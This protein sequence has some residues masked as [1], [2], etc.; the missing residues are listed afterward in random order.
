MHIRKESQPLQR[1]RL[2]TKSTPKI[3]SPSRS[4][5]VNPFPNTAIHQG[6]TRRRVLQAGIAAVGATAA[7]KLSRGASIA[8]KPGSGIPGQ[9]E[10]GSPF[11]KEVFG[12]D[13]PFFLPA[14]TDPFGGNKAVGD[15]STITDFN[16]FLGVIEA[17]GVNI[18]GNSYDGAARRW[19]C[20]VR[21][22]KGVFRDREG[23]TQRGAFGFF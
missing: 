11:L 8:A 20:D 4:E 15:S 7:F 13:I 16:G 19:G 22:M 2:W 6:L 3:D 1:P 21:F 12:I 17:D 10:N 9:L 5:Q 23:R 18:P 14:E